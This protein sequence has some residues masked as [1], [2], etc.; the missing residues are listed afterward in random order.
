MSARPVEYASTSASRRFPTEPHHTFY[1]PASPL[2][3]WG[4]P[5]PRLRREDSVPRVPRVLLLR[6]LLTDL[7]LLPLGNQSCKKDKN[8]TKDGRLPS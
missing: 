1:F 5:S 2:L 8:G 6:A 4:P 7:F 3:L